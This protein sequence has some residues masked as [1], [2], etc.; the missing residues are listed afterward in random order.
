[1]KLDEIAELSTGAGA[2]G[3]ETTS[4]CDTSSELVFEAPYGALSF[5]EIREQLDQS[6]QMSPENA[7]LVSNL[8]VVDAL[9]DNKQAPY[10]KLNAPPKCHRFPRTQWMG[11]A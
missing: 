4:L 9:L 3:P 10:P 11:P 8:A 2:L 5:A 1:M 6:V 7:N